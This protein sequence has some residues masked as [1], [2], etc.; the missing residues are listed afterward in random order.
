[1]TNFGVKSTFQSLLCPNSLGG[2]YF[3]KNFSQSLVKFKEAT[4]SP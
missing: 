2:V 4:E 1:M 3:G